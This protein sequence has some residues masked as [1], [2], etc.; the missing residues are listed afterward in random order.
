MQASSLVLGACGFLGS[1]LVRALLREGQ[2][3]VA[4][5]HVAPNDALLA[6]WVPHTQHSGGFCATSTQNAPTPNA[7]TPS[8]ND[9]LSIIVKSLRDIAD[10]SLAGINTVYHLASSTLPAQSNEAPVQDVEGNLIASLGLLNHL[11]GSPETQL[12]FASSGGTV[13]GRL[14]NANSHALP[15]TNQSDL[16]SFY[17][18]SPTEPVCSYGIVKLA[19][20]K[21]ISMHQALYG[22]RACTLRLSNPYGLGQNPDRPQGAVGVLLKKVLSNQPMTIW[23][24]GS[25]VRDYVAVDDVVAALLSAAKY[26]GTQSLFNIGSGVGTSLSELI[27]LMGEITG[28]TPQIIYEPARA[29]DVPRNVLNVDRARA[30][31]NWQPQ[32]T[33][34]AGLAALV[35]SARGDH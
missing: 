33:L 34:R 32:T 26:T 4:V 30:E 29:F 20:E 11:R 8:L 25:V 19:I 18:I 17:E 9:G 31:I 16:G 15:A 23:G 24:D 5:D 3:V 1:H 10:V 35:A 12:I 27:A 7:S 14:D 6:S 13:Y 22:L 28:Q 21:Y 2:R